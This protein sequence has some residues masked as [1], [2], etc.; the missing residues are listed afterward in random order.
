MCGEETVIKRSLK[1]TE[2]AR[3]TAAKKAVP[4]ANTLPV[5]PL[6]NRRRR[7]GILIGTVLIQCC[8]VIAATFFVVKTFYIPRQLPEYMPVAVQN[9]VPEP[10]SV[11]QDEQKIEEKTEVAVPQHQDIFIAEAQSSQSAVPVT[12][13][14][15]ITSFDINVNNE[16][17]AAPVESLQPPP[18]I[19]KTL[20][21]PVKIAE[22]LLP[23]DTTPPLTLADA[24]L[25][26][27]KIHKTYLAAP[28][29]ALEDAA[30]AVR[31]YKENGQ[32][33]PKSLY[34]LLGRTYTSLSWGRNLAD[35]IPAVTSMVLSGDNR[36][37]LL[38]L[39]DNTVWLWDLKKLEEGSEDNAEEDSR[40][41]VEGFCLDS[42]GKP[43][44]RLAFTPDLHWIIGGQTDGTICV[45][46][47]SQKNPASTATE[48][49][50]KLPELADIQISPDGQF[51]AARSFSS[52]PPFAADRKE[53][54][55]QVFFRTERKDLWDD[56]AREQTA[57]VLLWNLKK[58]DTGLIPAAYSVAYPASAV[59]AMQF[60]PDSTKL[61]LG[62]SDASVHLYRLQSEKFEKE[63]VVLRGH[64]GPVTQIAFAPN[65]EWIATGSQDN[66]V[67]LW[68]IQGS[69]LDADKVTLTGHFGW[70][71]ALAVDSNGQYVYSG[72]FDQTVKRWKVEQN[73]IE[74]AQ[75]IKPI[76]FDAD[77]GIVERI[78]PT[79]DGSKVVI[80]GRNG[81]LQIAELENLA[82]NSVTFH[83][84]ALLITDYTVSSDGNWMIFCYANTLNQENSGLRFWTLNLSGI[85]SG[86]FMEP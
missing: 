86:N 68:K 6:K 22:T 59:K 1:K 66:T 54:I 79:A 65:G 3:Q 29:S 21:E 36:W 62:G 78:T 82:D 15:V 27:E 70:I 39:Q 38:Q 14:K 51:L 16:E 45:W 13:Q 61:A 58:M 57:N 11:E 52:V 85:V 76:T 67:R 44:V 64:K 63:Q 42:S 40:H 48:F 53:S 9:S 33:L 8:I 49:R 26:L 35:S 23:A 17:F 20:D 73:R 12:E 24:N 18:E 28:E 74:T 4:T 55:Q 84:S 80:N 77:C 30:E 81:K 75:H 25:L 2:P 7:K 47:M 46:D 72:S 71:S 31:I 37:L 41:D 83:H 34:W 43:Y 5:I 32:E 69:H 50:E 56:P 19:P 10:V 60:S